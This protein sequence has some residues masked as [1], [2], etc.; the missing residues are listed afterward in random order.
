MTSIAATTYRALG[1][2]RSLCPQ[3]RCIVHRTREPE[4]RRLRIFPRSQS[5]PVSTF[6]LRRPWRIS[7]PWALYAGAGHVI[8]RSRREEWR[9]MA[10]GQSAAVVKGRRA[11]HLAEEAIGM[12]ASSQRSATF[13]GLRQG[14]ELLRPSACFGDGCRHPTASP[15]RLSLAAARLITRLM[16]N[17]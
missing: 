15:P 8:E 13:A 12:R 16:R 3:R 4:I 5:V 7:I 11:C 1:R 9:V 6:S 2:T 17:I 10:A 14:N